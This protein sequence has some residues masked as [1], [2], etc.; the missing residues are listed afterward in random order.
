MRMIR[1][2]GLV[3]G[4]GLM[5]VGARGQLGVYG[6]ATATK[7]PGYSVTDLA[8]SSGYYSSPAYTAWGGTGGLFYNFVKIGPFLK[9][10]VDGRLFHGSANENSTNAG[11]SNGAVTT[12]SGGARVEAHLLKFALKPYVQAEVG[13][14]SSSTG[15]TGDGGHFLYQIQFGADY[16]VFPHIDVRGEYGVGRS[17][18]VL[19]V[20]ATEH[21]VI[22][23]FGAGVV[24][25]L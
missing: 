11:S 20:G 2:V 17:S 16:T 10:G 9:I 13:G 22:Q 4:L 12:G 21:E 7:N 1:M 23:T 19:G 24:V 18:G 15:G 25:R 14:L 3:V 5:A 8:Y 6:M